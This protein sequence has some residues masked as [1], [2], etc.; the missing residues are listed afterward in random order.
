M[1]QLLGIQL[2]NRFFIITRQTP[3]RREREG[4]GEG[5]R[6]REGER[7]RGR[8]RKREREEGREREGGINIM[9]PA[10]VLIAGIHKCMYTPHIAEG[11]VCTHTCM[12][13]PVFHCNEVAFHQ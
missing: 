1:S 13:L 3:E 9:K 6:E 7:E 2:L 8:G 11:T 4:E 5:G 12:S 10:E